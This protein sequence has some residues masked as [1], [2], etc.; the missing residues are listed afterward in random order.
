MEH[1]ITAG[2]HRH[3]MVNIPILIVH[4]PGNRVQDARHGVRVGVVLVISR[5]QRERIGMVHPVHH[6]V[7]DIIVQGSAMLQRHRLA[8]VMDLI[9]AA[10]NHQTVCIQV[11]QHQIHV[12][13]HVV[14]DIIWKMERVYQTPKLVQVICLALNMET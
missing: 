6:V 14:V 8:M 11:L 5:V 12:H 2:Q 9:H 7:P 4:R 13:G 10:I 1:V 3:V